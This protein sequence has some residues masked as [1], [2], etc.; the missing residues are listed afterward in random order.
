[1]ALQMDNWSYFTP[2]NGVISP[3]LQLVLGPTLQHIL[4][5]LAK[6]NKHLNQQNLGNL[7][8][9]KSLPWMLTGHFGDRIPLQNSLR[10]GGEFPTGFP[11]SP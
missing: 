10:F 7:W 6:S 1:M 3:Y 5:F 2:I 4:N 8:N 11:R 9:H